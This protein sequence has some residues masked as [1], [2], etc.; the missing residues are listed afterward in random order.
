MI[1]EDRLELVSDKL[2]IN[3]VEAFVE[4]ICD[5]YN[6]YNDY[7]G[8]ILMSV[9]EAYT[10][11]VQHGNKFEKDKKV[12]IRF[13]S[14]ATGLAFYV[15]DQGEGFNIE[16]VPDPTDVN[17][18]GKEGKGIFT[19]RALADNVEFINNGNT[20]K[21]TYLISSINREMSE[22]RAD[23]YHSYINQGVKNNAHSN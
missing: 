18:N 20:V 1:R 10:N 21:M 6:I 7:Y 12:T 15:E 13:E 8:N 16:T 19:I 22:K 14:Q 5:A 11:A 3:K 9:I 17:T 4:Q 2:Y 23:L